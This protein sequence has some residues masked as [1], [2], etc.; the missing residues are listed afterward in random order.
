MNVPATVK[1]AQ[2]EIV[3][4]VLANLVHVVAVIVKSSLNTL[5]TMLILV[6]L[7]YN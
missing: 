1:V 5:I 6:T 3:K 7:Y 2:K 4:T